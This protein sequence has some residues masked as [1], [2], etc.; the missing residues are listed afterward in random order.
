MLNF[1]ESPPR[2][3]AK[4]A[5][6][7]GLFE[8]DD[9]RGDVALRDEELGERAARVGVAG[10]E[11]H[12]AGECV[13]RA[14]TVAE[15]V[16]AEHAEALAQIE[17]ALDVAALG[18]TI[19]E[20]R[21]DAFE[22]GPLRR[23]RADGDERDERFFVRRIFFERGFE[24]PETARLVAQSTERDV[25]L[26]EAKQPA[27]AR[28]FGLG[29]DRAECFD[30]LRPAMDVFVELAK[31]AQHVEIVGADVFARARAIRSRRAC[32]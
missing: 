10:P 20:A 26:R 24:K 29:A 30:D 19:D 18:V 13:D 23:A 31:R 5:R 32:R 11:L 2:L 3:R 12:G 9:R 21:V 8:L 1:E 22:L 7:G 14:G 25:R 16:A 17:R 15:L 4:S 28:V 27:L 6:C